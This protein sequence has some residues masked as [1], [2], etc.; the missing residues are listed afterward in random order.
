MIWIVGDLLQKQQILISNLASTHSLFVL[1]KGADGMLA[2]SQVMRYWLQ[3]YQWDP[4]PQ[5][6]L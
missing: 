6:A 3:A 4:A 2:C 1:P 5:A